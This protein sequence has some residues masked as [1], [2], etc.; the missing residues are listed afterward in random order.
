MTKEELIEQLTK[1][2][3]G[4][5]ALKS[6]EDW[7]VS[8][9]WNAVHWDDFLLRDVLYTMELGLAEFANRHVDSSYVRALAAEAAGTLHQTLPIHHSAILGKG[10][11][12]R[13]IES[14]VVTATLVQ[15]AA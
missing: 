14:S 15:F 7:L 3:T 5:L 6:F 9:S 10:I 13:Q 2:A 4:R 1:V 12:I 8:H 11:G